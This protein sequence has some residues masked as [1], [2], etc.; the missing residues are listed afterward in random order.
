MKK[1]V[2]ETLRKTPHRFFHH[3]VSRIYS[4]SFLFVFSLILPSLSLGEAPGNTDKNVPL[5]WPD[6]QKRAKDAGYKLINFQELQALIQSEK[7]VVLLDARPDYEYRD[8]H[9]PRARNFE[10]HLGHKYLLEPERTGSLKVFLGRD[11]DGWIIT[12]CRNFK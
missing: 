4:F 9:I 2:R 6:T 3:V 1:K 10:F 5:W 8:G 12:Y 11:R 7:E